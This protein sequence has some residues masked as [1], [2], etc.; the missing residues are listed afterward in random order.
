MSEDS[1]FDEEAHTKLLNTINSLGNNPKKGPLIRKCSKKVQV[2]EL[3]DLIRSTKN[4]D[5]VKKKLVTKRQGKTVGKDEPRTLQAPSHRLV[6]E[7][8][9]SSIAYSDIRKDLEEWASIVKKNRLAEQLVFPLTEDPPVQRTA[10]DLV[11][12]FKPRTSMEVEL[13]K[14]LKTSNNNLRDGEE[15]TEA[16]LELIRA[17][18]LK[19]ARAKWVQL[20][21]MRALVGYREAKLKRQAKI[22]SKSYHRHMKRQKR[23]QMIKE[24]EEMM[25]KNPEAAKE[26]LEEIDRQRILERATLKHRS[27]KGVQQLSRYASKNKNFKKVYEEQIRL[28]RELVEKHGLEK[29]SDCDSET[30]STNAVKLTSAKMLEKAAEILE[31]EEHDK[32]S[33]VPKLKRKLY[34]M[35]EQERETLRKSALRATDIKFISHRRH[36]L[37][38]DAANESSVR[39]EKVE[40]K[41]GPK[42]AVSSEEQPNKM[43]H[44]RSISGNSGQ[45]CA[46][47]KADEQSKKDRKILK[48][49]KSCKKMKNRKKSK[50]VLKDVD[51]DQLFDKAEKELTDYALKKCELLKLDDEKNKRSRDLMPSAA[52]SAVIP[53]QKEKEIAAKTEETVTDISLDPRH[54]LQIETMAL[55][56]VS[57]NFVEVLEDTNQQVEDQEEIIAKAFEDVDV[58]GD[59][60]AEKEAAEAAENPKDIDL[61]L[62][63]WGSWTGPGITNRKKN[64]FVIKAPRKKRKDAG[65]TGLIISEAVDPSIEKIQL[66]S[67]PFPYTTVED[68]ETVVRQPLGKEW[69]PQ[70]VHMKLIRPQIVTKAGRIIKPL[71]KSVLENESDEEK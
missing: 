28:G 54:F 1:D 2:K 25:V 35:R 64:R 8:I 51:I 4:V 26:K 45:D 58:I 3:V 9:E 30:E 11:L 63:G 37:D 67:I 46:E 59:F 60:E 21:K 22:K 41:W 14:L 6:R 47:K 34:E 16:E 19:E 56:Q 17:M 15:Y 29:D 7:R 62:Q 18:S 36:E 24:F 12:F 20:K 48:E 27:G 40:M 69:N 50:D 65:K 5:D 49:K 43:Q 70:R 55:P 61:T 68:Y 71:G 39:N 23:K 10:S 33:A 32:M 66:K 38:P 57:A 44:Q 53:R 42:E 31:R 52:E 13:A